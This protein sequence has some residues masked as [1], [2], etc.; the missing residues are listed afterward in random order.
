MHLANLRKHRKKE[1]GLGEASNGNEDETGEEA[2]KADG[3][4]DTDVELAVQGQHGLSSASNN[5]VC[6]KDL[7]SVQHRRH[8]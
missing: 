6:G 1:E 8:L 2:Q 3:V 5:G 7:S 4:L